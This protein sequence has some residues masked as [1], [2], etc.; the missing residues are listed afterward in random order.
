MRTEWGDFPNAIIAH[1]ANSITA[2][3]KY[4]KAKAGDIDFALD[5]V[6]ELVT[7][8]FY[9]QVYTAIHEDIEDVYVL[10]VHAEEQLGRNKLPVAFAMTISQ[11]LAVNIETDIV[12]ANKV[13]RTEANG[14]VRLL[15]R[16][17]FDGEVTPRHKYLIVDDVITQGGTLADLRAYI[18]NNGGHVILVSAL[19]GKHHSAKLPITK[20]TLGQ[21]AQASR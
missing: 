4:L 8:E 18:E 14:V 13:H 20:V 11:N 6:D 5:L 2:H 15:K 19:N 9:K 10:P 17:I 16:V 21:L 3:R 12:Q 1:V 7:D